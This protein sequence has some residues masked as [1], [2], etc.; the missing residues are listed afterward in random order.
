MKLLAKENVPEV[1]RAWSG[2]YKIL[3]PA[4]KEQGDCIF[5]TFDEDT[6]TL[7][8][9]K[10][11]MPPK[12]AVFPPSSVLFSVQQGNYT[13]VPSE[14][15]SLLFGI[16]S[17]DLMG[18]HQLKSFYLRDKEDIYVQKKMDD[19]VVVVHA[20]S[21]PQNETCFCTTMQSGPYAEHGFDLQLFDMENDFLVEVGSDVGRTLT[22]LDAFTE[23]TEADAAE[24]ISLIKQKAFDSIPLVPDVAKA[25]DILKETGACDEV[26]ERL[27][28]K[29]ITCGG[30]V[31]VCPTCTCFTVTDRVFAHENGER[32]R[33]WDT[34]L[35]GGFTR[36]ASGHNPR[37]T[38]GSR[39]KRRH[40]HK[41][42]YYNEVDIQG[43]LSGCV[44][45]GRCS[46]FCPVHIG[47]LEVVK[48]IV[49]KTA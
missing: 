3:C 5:D 30:C 28:S 19:I 35:Y 43:T 39:L 31:Y 26:W 16:R 36:E 8:Y 37:P 27:G 7:D 34:C 6:F 38:Q 20:C 18:L 17:C 41:L 45:C 49:D 23:F 13:R 33:S 4:K 2:Q 47:T 9:R 42:L 15:R 10:P 46:D 44:G 25:M 1:L 12:S 21:R 11:P 32:I 40:E 29:C 48:A 24:R 14:E 22:S